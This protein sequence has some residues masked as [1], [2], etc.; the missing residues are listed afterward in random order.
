VTGRLA[1]SRFRGDTWL[2]PT[3]PPHQGRTRGGCLLLADLTGADLTTATLFR[4]DLVQVCYNDA[5]KWPEPCGA[6]RRRQRP[7]APPPPANRQAPIASHQ[8][9]TGGMISRRMGD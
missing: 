3:E 2:G 4:R 9:T 5:T 1:L 8:P 7:G 6:A